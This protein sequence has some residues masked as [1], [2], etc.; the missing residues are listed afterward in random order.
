MRKTLIV[1]LA[2]VVLVAV[3]TGLAVAGTL[4]LIDS[5]DRSAAAPVP[6]SAAPVAPAYDPATLNAC[7]H[8]ADMTAT[9]D[10]DQASLE[11]AQSARVSASTSDVDALREAAA[12]FSG[13]DVPGSLIDNV[14]ALTV[15][16]KVSTWCLEHKVTTVP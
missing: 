8:A 10:D 7:R 3:L 6:S 11:A 1:I 9:I 15:G 16:M 2:A 12:E 13:N 4:L 14:N 5:A